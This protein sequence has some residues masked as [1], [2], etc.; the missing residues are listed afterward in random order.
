MRISQRR[1]SRGI[2]ITGRGRVERPQVKIAGTPRGERPIYARVGAALSAVA[3][4]AVAVLLFRAFAPLP[5]LPTDSVATALL[6]GA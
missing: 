1:H 6:P 3:V 2:Q 4:V 5:E